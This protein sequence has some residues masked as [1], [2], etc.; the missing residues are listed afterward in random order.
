VSLLGKSNRQAR[1]EGF[2]PL[3]Y[4]MF[5][6]VT[7]AVFL[8]CVA[9]GSVP[10][11]LS[12]SARGL[13]YAIFGGDRPEANV[14]IAST[15]VPRAIAAG[16]MGASLSISG[17]A[18]QGLLK[19]PLA[20]GS[21][22]GVSSG[23]SLGATL[24]IAFGIDFALPALGLS[25]MTVSAAM[26]ALIS[27]L[28]I[29]TLSYKLDGSLSTNTIILVGIIFAMFVSSATSLII[30]FSDASHTQRIVFWTMGSLD[31]VDFTKVR[32]LGAT[33]LIFGTI[34]IAHGRELNA[35]AIG[36]DNARS[37]G[38]NVRR[39][40]LTV[41]ICVAALIGVSVSVA[42]TI[43]FV[44]LVAPHITRMIIGPNH[45]RLLPAALFGGATFLMLCDL[46]SRSLVHDGSRVRI[47]P[48]GVVTSLIGAVL[49]VI[50]FYRSRKG[51]A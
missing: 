44:G 2:A 36:E 37:I 33:L 11:S 30:T 40:K 43:G 15:R 27:L 47:I 46:A 23:A 21:T 16:L 19:N 6:V 17:A 8:L 28:I 29:L 32:L 24:S 3:A 34:L 49:F 9:V 50:V 25:A 45:R 12:E 20:D 51:G 48:I 4:A 26:F 38:V 31:S 5:A 22:I 39:V 18:M 7:I 1:R 14:I 42:G 35:F 13:V 41:L 10:V